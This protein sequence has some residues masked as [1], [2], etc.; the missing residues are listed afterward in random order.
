MRRTGSWK[1]PRLLP[2]RGDFG[3]DQFVRSIFSS[4]VSIGAVASSGASWRAA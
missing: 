4:Q 3:A 2:D 1:K